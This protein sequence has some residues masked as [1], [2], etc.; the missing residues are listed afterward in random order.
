MEFLLQENIRKFYPFLVW[1]GNCKFTDSA[2]YK[3]TGILFIT[4]GLFLLKLS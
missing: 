4:A 2:L 3:I 1:P